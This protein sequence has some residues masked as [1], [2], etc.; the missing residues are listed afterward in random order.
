M[1]IT[2][3][4]FALAFLGVLGASTYCVVRDGQETMVGGAPLFLISFFFGAMLVFL[5]VVLTQEE[6]TDEL[7][8]K[9]RQDSAGKASLARR[10][11]KPGRM[12]QDL[13]QEGETTGND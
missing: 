13:R 10:R 11:C 3:V 6:K 8:T 2:R 12:G 9:L 1:I 7:S 5:E 4:S